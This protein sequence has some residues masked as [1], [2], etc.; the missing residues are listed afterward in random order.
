MTTCQVRQDDVMI[1]E[2]TMSDVLQYLSPPDDL[3]FHLSEE[4]SKRMEWWTGREIILGGGDLTD[5]QG[6]GVVERAGEY[7][8][9]VIPTCLKNCLPRGVL[10]RFAGLYNLCVCFCL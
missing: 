6:C 1:M 7:G 9:S 4:K 10:Y 3:H 5:C 2:M 8:D